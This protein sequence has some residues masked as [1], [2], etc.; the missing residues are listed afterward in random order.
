MNKEIKGYDRIAPF[1]KDVT[2]SRLGVEPSHEVIS[3]WSNLSR[4]VR[5]ADGMLD[6]TQDK[7]IR[8]QI[9]KDGY[10]YLAG[11]NLELSFG[12]E[13]Y[14]AEMGELKD[15]LGSVT[16]AKKD[17]F[18]RSLSNLLKVSESLRFVE[19]P[20]ELAKLTK[21]EGQITARL[22]TSLLL[23]NSSEAPEYVRFLTR[24]GRVGNLFDT[25][26]DFND[27]YKRGQTR[28]KPS[29]GGYAVMAVYALEDAKYVIRN[30]RS[31]SIG[32]LVGG[33]YH[34]IAQKETPS[35]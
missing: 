25:M 15:F 10:S 29:L 11:S 6:N 30:S 7:T 1:F 16:P 26:V 20:A 24:I 21:L 34:T 28:I 5:M 32:R 9:S 12:E 2:R 3:A 8:D 27:D 14:K 35:K 33:V 23:E 31:R 17:N 13:A 18:L 4:A 19:D 22:F